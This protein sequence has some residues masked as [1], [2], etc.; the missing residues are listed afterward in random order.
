MNASREQQYLHFNKPTDSIK[1]KL[2]SHL[3]KSMPVR[4]FK[5]CKG[6]CGTYCTNH[7]FTDYINKQDLHL[8]KYQGLQHTTA[9]SLN[10]TIYG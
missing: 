7:I 6:L 2:S 8:L 10:E 4:V 9:C 1:N 5:S 3:H